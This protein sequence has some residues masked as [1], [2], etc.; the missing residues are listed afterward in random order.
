LGG[1]HRPLITL[2]GR[3][4]PE[5]LVVGCRVARARRRLFPRPEAAGGDGRGQ[6]GA[7]HVAS[8]NLWDLVGE[9][10]SGDI[11]NIEERPSGLEMMPGWGIARTNVP[12]D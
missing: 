6:A 2:W 12:P 1:P 5:L 3:A 8:N 9:E 10:P 11:L 7:G 4:A